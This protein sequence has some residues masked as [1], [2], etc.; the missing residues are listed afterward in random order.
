MLARITYFRETFATGERPDRANE[1]NATDSSRA[2]AARSTSRAPGVDALL[3]LDRFADA[4]KALFVDESDPEAIEAASVHPVIVY[5]NVMVP[6]M[7]LGVHIDVPAFRGLDRRRTPQWL[8]AALHSSGLFERWRLKTATGVSWWSHAGGGKFVFYPH[9]PAGPVQVHSTA[10]GSSVV[11]DT[12]TVYHGVDRVATPEGAPEQMPSLS[13]GMK[14]QLSPGDADVEASA[15][16]E[17]RVGPLPTRGE[18]WQVIDLD[19]RTVVANYS[20]SDVRLSISWKAFVFAN[21]QERELWTTHTDDLDGDT[22]LAML[23]ED[24]VAR[25]RVPACTEPKPSVWLARRIAAEYLVFPP[26]TT[27]RFP[28]GNYCM[29]PGLNLLCG[30][31]TVLD[32][33]P[34]VDPLSAL[35]KAAARLSGS[36]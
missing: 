25:G 36:T 28:S 5:A 7:E 6:G 13:P 29:L 35:P 10:F 4:A 1:A 20:W 32:F 33:P 23:V 14:L 30:S 15:G 18:Q 2:K 24:M 31:S 9:G 27:P 19:G 34:L 26:P 22:A 21:D 3:D 16:G 12:D 11:V 8:L 17:V